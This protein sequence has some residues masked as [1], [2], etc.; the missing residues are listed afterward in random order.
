MSWSARSLLTSCSL[1][2]WNCV[3][4]CL[5]CR[6]VDALQAE[7]VTSLTQQL[8]LLHVTKEFQQQVKAGANSNSSSSGAGRPGSSSAGT[9]GRAGSGGAGAS[10]AAASA[11]AAASKEVA[12]LENLLKVRESPQVAAQNTL[13]HMLS[14]SRG[15]VAWR[16][17]RQW[18]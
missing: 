8:Q 3:G 2:N 11:S 6:S 1:H 7:D 12:S 17:Q 13:Q 9:Q 4:G 16:M 5:R 10:A 18:S 14:E 15:A